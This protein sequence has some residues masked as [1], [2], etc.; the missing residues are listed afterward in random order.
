[1]SFL[2]FTSVF[3]SQHCIQ[4]ATVRQFITYTFFFGN[5]LSCFTGCLPEKIKRENEIRY[6]CTIALDQLK[7]PTDLSEG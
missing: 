2:N 1:M 7:V 6:G 4:I 5:S 3:I